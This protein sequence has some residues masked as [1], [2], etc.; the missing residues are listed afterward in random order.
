MASGTCPTDG[1]SLMPRHE[2]SRPAGGYFSSAVR[3]N[4]RA[5]GISLIAGVAS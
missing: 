5:T 1:A 4:Q 3:V 2:N